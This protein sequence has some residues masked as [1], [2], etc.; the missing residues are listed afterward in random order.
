MEKQPGSILKTKK[1][2]KSTLFLSVI[3]LVKTGIIFSL[4]LSV[5]DI[6]VATTLPV[7]EGE[8]QLKIIENTY[9]NLRISNSLASMRSHGVNTPEGMFTELIVPEYSFTFTIGN[10]KIPLLR[11][12]IEIPIGAEIDVRI[13]GYSVKEYKLEELGIE[14][15]IIPV[16]PPVPKSAQQPAD[17]IVNEDIYQQDKFYPS[18]IATAE[19]LGMLRGIRIARINIAPVQYNPVTEVIKV[20]SDLEIEFVYV[21]GNISKTLTFKEK[22]N[23]PFFKGLTGQLFNYKNLENTRD[24][25]TKYPVKYV[26]VSDPMFE[27][28]LQ[29]F[30]QWKTKKGFTVVEAYTD[31]PAVGSTTASIKN[32]LQSLYESGTFLDP[33]PS[34]VLF[35]GDI[36]QIPSFSSGGHVTD[37]YYC[38]YTGD[39]FPEVYYGRFSATNM[40][41]LIPQIDKTLEYEK[42]QMPDPYF[43]NEV[44][45]IAGMDAGHGSTWG[46]GQINYG[47]TYYF[48]EAHGI[49][50]HTYLYPESG[51][52]SAD[53]IQD[54]S[55]GVAY[56]N[57]TAHGNWDGWS[58]PS[59]KISDIPTLQNQ[60][61]YPLMIGNA[62]LTN[63][64]NV[65]EC[66]GE[67]LLRAENKGALGYIG[68]SNSTYWDEDYYWGV[69]VGD[70]VTYPTYEGTTLGAYDRTFHDH[71][72]PFE[73]WYMTQDQMIFA[74]NLAVT[75]GSSSYDYYWEVY[76]LMG[77]PSLMIYFSYPY[78][79]TANYP[80]IIPVNTSQIV[81]NTDPYAYAALSY[82]G[83]LLGAAQ[84]NINGTANIN[85]DPFIDP[86]TIDVV[87]THQNKQPHFGT[88]E[89]AG[90]PFPPANPYPYNG[91]A[92]I[93]PFTILSWNYGNGG[94]PEY[95]ILF[96]GTDNPPTNIINGEII[97]D[98]IYNS[99]LDLQYETQY[100]WRIDSYNE[101]GSATGDI[102]CF[103]TIYPPDEDFESGDFSSNFW[104]FAGDSEWEIDDENVFYGNY[105]ARTGTIGDNESSS[106][107]IQLEIENLFNTE[108]KFYKMIS[109]G[110]N[111]KLQFFIDNELVDEWSGLTAFNEE[112]F[113][114]TAGFHTFEWKYIKDVEGSSGED[115]AWIDH[116][117][118]P[119]LMPPSVNAGSDS[120]ICEGDTY[121][122]SGFACNIYSVN[123]ETSGTGT[124]SDSTIL[125]PVYTP[126][127]EDYT[128][129]EVSL[130]LTA[131]SKTDFIS[132]EMVLSFI[133]LP[134][135]PETPEGPEYVDL[136]YTTTSEYSTEGANFALQYEWVLE[137]DYAG[138]LNNDDLTCILIWDPGFLGEAFLAVKG[139]NE[140]G[141]GPFSELLEILVDNTV[142]LDEKMTITSINILPNPNSGL[143]D[144]EIIA[145]KDSFINIQIFDI[146]GNKVYEEN[147]AAINCR[148]LNTIDLRK[149]NKGLYFIFIDGEN[150]KTVKKII[151]R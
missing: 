146:I 112:S 77:D 38:E 43:L 10:P 25:V 32:Y 70:I 92:F 23:T 57:Y 45:M 17:F 24:T 141:D 101:Y 19:I 65:A 143:F 31:D 149:Q 81:I 113:P 12:L 78:P 109:S 68:A 63:K 16:Q 138:I 83:N 80:G 29:P 60:G 46:N 49:T 150:I 88:I 91:A 2:M 58:D 76:H 148:Y 135:T 55:N 75:E 127:D 1:T 105:S 36:D 107:I 50:S 41:Q 48:N 13:I 117:Y 56:A 151:I 103:N 139:I 136:Y 121:N 62:C 69:G 39:Y 26:I 4:I 126:G 145:D 96:L 34:F 130:T 7:A 8:N 93:Q 11:K 61:K 84:A 129:G 120:I 140:C 28:T 3:R 33:A 72:E 110:M 59:F 37:L 115:C 5:L 73:D 97:Y 51:S 95:Y 122:L 111:D 100:F 104:H 53:I 142:G 116:I 42:F 118:F 147:H 102:W 133:P 30:V 52:H 14:Y 66:F 119:P 85:I 137:P 6:A 27:T 40:A 35:V 18:D 125:A 67:A 87:I 9:S 79:V 54:V 114:I 89:F 123:W 86:I 106:L 47:T 131:Y 74:G 71:G 132:D 64:F 134:E 94:I 20:Y 22:N 90:A 144:V 44:D 124:F 21:D 99:G 82:E 98:T 15:P 108:I 128:I